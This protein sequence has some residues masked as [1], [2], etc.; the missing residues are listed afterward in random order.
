MYCI[1]GVQ[2]EQCYNRLFQHFTFPL[3]IILSTPTLPPALSSFFSPSHMHIFH[4]SLYMRFYV[5]E[6]KCSLPVW[7]YNVLPPN[8][9][10]E[11]HG[12]L[13]VHGNTLSVVVVAVDDDCM[14]S[15]EEFGP[16]AAPEQRTQEG[17][18]RSGVFGNTLTYHTVLIQ[19]SSYDC[20]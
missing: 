5:R 1:S 18:Y 10:T 17:K 15:S 11:T 2:F 6:K 14:A 19:D 7:Q 3:L 20:H 8:T 4:S 12:V 13:V 16:S 9:Y